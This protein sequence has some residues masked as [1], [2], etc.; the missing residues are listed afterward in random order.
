[1]RCLTLAACA[2]AALGSGASLLRLASRAALHSHYGPGFHHAWP[3]AMMGVGLLL[4]GMSLAV[5][6]GLH[7]QTLILHRGARLTLLSGLT[8]GTTLLLLGL[9]AA[10]TPLL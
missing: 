1:M 9:L 5:R 4:A 6:L 2:L 3:L 8:I 7:D 10:L